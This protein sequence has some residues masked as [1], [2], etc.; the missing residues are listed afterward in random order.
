MTETRTGLHNWLG[1][2][3]TRYYQELVRQASRVASEIVEQATSGIPRTVDVIRKTKTSDA[4]MALGVPAVWAAV[5]GLTD[6]PAT[7]FMPNQWDEARP[8][9][10]VE[11]KEGSRTLLIADVPAA[12]GIAAD[13]L[14]LSDKIKIDDP[15]YGLVHFDVEEVNPIRGTGLIHIHVSY[16]RDS[17]S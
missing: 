10:V 14:L 13:K 1:E 7:L 4:D 17:L 15:V 6:L 3:G 8:G 5:D 16:S 11:V 12:G 9:K 2:S